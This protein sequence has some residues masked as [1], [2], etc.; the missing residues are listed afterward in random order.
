M[1]LF[2]VIFKHHALLRSEKNL[3][4]R[5]ISKSVSSHSTSFLRKRTKGICEARGLSIEP[6]GSEISNKLARGE[7]RHYFSGEEEEVH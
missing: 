1:R 7:R 2:F 6:V 5:N 3:I 4:R